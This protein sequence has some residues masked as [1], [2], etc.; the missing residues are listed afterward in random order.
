MFVS[1]NHLFLKSTLTVALPLAL[2]VLLRLGIRFKDF[3]VLEVDRSIL[4]AFRHTMVIQQPL[5]IKPTCG[6]IG[7]CNSRRHWRDLDKQ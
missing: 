1:G 2:R 7:D 6:R 3:T 4:F 5:A